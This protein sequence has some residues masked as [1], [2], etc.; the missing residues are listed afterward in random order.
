M[1]IKNKNALI[2]IDLQ[3][4]FCPG[5]A[6]EVRDGDKII[7]IINKI[8]GKFYKIIATQDWH[9]KDHISFASN[10][11]GKKIYDVIKI[12][13]VEQVL[14]PDHC[15]RGTYGAELH[16]DL[17]TGNIN[18][19]L[20]KGTDKNIDSYSAFIEND[21]K[22]LTGLSGYLNSL[23]IKQI[24]L[25]G[26]ATDYCV[27][28]SAMDALKFGYDTYVIIDACRGVDVPNN[29]VKRVIDIMKNN[30]IKIIK[31]TDI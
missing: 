18:L 12:D 29:N 1:S 4:D 15:V 26:L 21:K 24:F 11:Q 17:R 25:V 3:N 10:Y 6:L 14:W 16:K 8:Q 7:P 31:S 27:Y 28:Y 23:K 9:P 20:R 19:I 5:G 30:G 22:T 2:I 13:N